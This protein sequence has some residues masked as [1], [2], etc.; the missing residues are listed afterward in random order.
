MTGDGVNDAP[1][2]QQA[3]IGIAM[4]VAGTEVSKVRGPE[5]KYDPPLSIFFSQ[6]ALLVCGKRDITR[7]L[8]VTSIST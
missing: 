1:A 6:L 2:L 3:A 5:G 7:R 4:G 8:Q